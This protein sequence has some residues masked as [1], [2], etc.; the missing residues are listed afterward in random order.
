[1]SNLLATGSSALIAFQRALSTVSHNVAN[2]NTEGY[3]RQRTEFAARDATFYGHGFQGTGV[4]IV[5]IKRMADSLATARLLDSGGELSRL[6]QMS[7]LSSRMDS[8][9]SEKATGITAPWSGFFDSVSA[10]SSNASSSADRQSMLAQANALVTRFNQIDK[11]LDGLNDEVNNGLVAGTSE[12]NRLAAEIAQLNGKIGGNVNASADLLDR[13]DQLIS[14][15]V[16][17]TGGNAATQ[18]GGQVNVFTAGGQPLVVGATASK[19]VTLADPYRPER[20]QV[21]LETNG[22]RTS[23]DNRAMGGQMGGLMEFRSTVLDPAVAEL[24]RIAVSLAETFNQGHAAGMD[25]Y[26]QMGGDFFNLTPPRIT[27]HSGNGGNAV[28]QTSLGD[29]SALNAQNVL[30]RFDGSAWSATHP[31]TGAAIPLTGTGTAADPLVV[32]GV[33][34]VLA[35]GT[36]AANDRFLLQPTAGAAGTLSLAITD[37]S[38]IAAATPI[39]GSVDL[40]NLGSGKL[41]GLKVTDASNANLLTPVDIEFIDATQYTVGGT[42]P[43]T[44]T[45]GQTISY[46][47]WS[48]ALDGAPRAGDTFT[49]S[50]NGANSSD[51]GNAKLLANLDDA[52]A[53]NGGTLTLN[54][55][56]AGLTTSVG[57]A[58]RQADYSAEA[59]QVIH[60]QAQAARDSISGVNL[61]EEAADLMRLQQAYQAAAQII[62][63]ADSL[64]QS[65]LN[66]VRR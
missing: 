63:T 7:V 53:L 18:D 46:N 60:D 61:D 51:N 4:Q 26:G 36:P 9:F 47:G 23:L 32:N 20:L 31:Q 21:A 66:A 40:T 49:V 34:V 33:E 64:F 44:Y 16:S 24:G 45:A 15:L 22:I 14:Q 5:D 55:A 59:Q 37:P 57:S 6:Q 52:R 27:S 29:L 25:L 58:A 38:R 8:L 13:R 43:F 17:Y 28:L 48:L 11:H 50:A 10:L 19:L 41:S 54:G 2:V 42:G 30:L 39:K 56:V 62:S 65:L 35:S 1:M 12:V 3:S